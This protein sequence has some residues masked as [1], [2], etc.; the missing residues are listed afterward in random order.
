M[1]FPVF[2]EESPAFTWGGFLAIA[3]AVMAIQR[4]IAWLWWLE[5]GA[6][7]WVATISYGLYLWHYVFVRSELPVGAALP[8]AADRGR[9]C[10]TGGRRSP[11]SWRHCR[12]W[13]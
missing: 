3:P 9:P 10:G 5:V 13:R 8:L 1:F 4:A 7:V 11:P 6:L 2:G 12:R